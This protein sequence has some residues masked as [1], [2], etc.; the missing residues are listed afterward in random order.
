[1]TEAFQSLAFMLCQL[2][3][4]ALLFGPFVLRKDQ[5]GGSGTAKALM[6]GIALGIVVATAAITT[7]RLN[8]SRLANAVAD[9]ELRPRE[10]DKLTVKVLRGNSVVIRFDPEACL[11]YDLG[12]IDCGSAYE[13]RYDP[14]AKRWTVTGLNK[15]SGKPGTYSS[16]N[17]DRGRGCLGVWG[18]LFLFDEDGVVFRSDNRVGEIRIKEEKRPPSK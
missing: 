9:D 18:A 12:S 4:L 7:G 16:S 6:L 1:M 10:A 11:V 5:L 2:L 15:Q 17:C 13:G 8:S 14:W 3:V